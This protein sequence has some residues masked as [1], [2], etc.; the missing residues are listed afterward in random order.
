[1]L[2]KQFLGLCLAGCLGVG[3]LPAALAQT[4]RIAHFSH[5]GSVATLGAVVDN[6]G[7]VMDHRV[8]KVTRLNDS[9]ALMEGQESRN[10]GPWYPSKWQEQYH[11]GKRIPVKQALAQ[12]RGRYPQA[13]FVGF[14][15]ET[16]RKATYRKGASGSVWLGSPPTNGPVLLAVLATLAGVDWLLAGKPRPISA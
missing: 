10:G 13:K 16:K 2:A 15:G 8:E 5:G 12:L 3:G 4:G 11:E 7:L 9:I 14:D 1:M 6:F